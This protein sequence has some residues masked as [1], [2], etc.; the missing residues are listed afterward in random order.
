MINNIIP[1]SS[2]ATTS[3]F[4]FRRLHPKIFIG[5]AS[6]RYA[7]WIGQIYTGQ[8]YEG[9]IT[10]RSK[11]IAG[12]SFKEETLPIESV[13]EYF[14]HFPVL[15]IDYTFY[16]PL[17]DK[18]GQPAKNFHVLKNY[19]Q[20]INANDRVILKIPQMVS[21]QKIRYGSKYV[22]NETYLNPDIFFKRFY[23][24]ANDI[25][26]DSLAGMI[27]EQEYQLNKE[28]KPTQEMAEELDQFYQSIPKDSRYHIELRTGAYLY[29]PVLQVLEKHGIGQV[30][31]HWTWLPRLK[32]QLDRAEGKVFNSGNQRIV[33]LMTPHG[34]RYEKAYTR[35]YPFDKLVDGMLQQ[36]MVQD[37]V[38]IMRNAVDENIETNILIN[39]RSGGNA[40]LIAERIAQEFLGEKHLKID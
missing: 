13:K 26:G 15:E 12:K 1:T 36:K 35:A 7:G 24:P 4:Q 3:R 8:N 16:S 28:R 34:M 11:K 25:L 39:N 20:Y 10:K 21:A 40:P 5:T 14:Q 19:A 27:F 2:S 32:N 18:D 31:S 37:T 33:R 30:L 9:R 22:K 38:D 6:D 17:L 29:G 23:E